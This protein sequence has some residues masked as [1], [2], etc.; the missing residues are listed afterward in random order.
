MRVTLAQVRQSRLPQVVGL[1]AGDTPAIAAIVN[2]AQERLILAAGETG[3]FGGW[4]RVAFTVT[5]ANPYITLPRT[6]ARLINLDVCRE[7]VEIHNEFYEF[8]PGGIGLMPTPT[9]DDWCGVLGGYERGV[10]PT[11]V[12]LPATSYLRVY[13]TDSRDVNARM[14]ITGLD[15]ASMPIYSTDGFENPTGFYLRFQQPFAT[16][17]FEVSAISAVQKDVTYGDVILKAVDPDTL[18]ETTLSR[19]APAETHPTYRRYYIT[20][21]PNVCCDGTATI[22]V[23]GLGKLEYIPVYQDTDHVL[24][25]NIPALIEEVQAIRYSSMDLKDAA[26][27]EQKHH[28]KAIRL[29]QDELRHY[30][31]EQ[32]PAVSV[33]VWRGAPLENSG[34][35]RII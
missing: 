7:P 26:V 5:R 8:L 24:I 27:L 10:Y 19:Y 21:L 17:E 35:G 34:I 28:R 3:F 18:V 4:T 23:Q 16:T 25:G 29:L 22:T 31:G 20:R 33:D 6:L 11:L 12:D 1:C 13:V 32:N 15:A 14:L 9:Q 30:M 2:E